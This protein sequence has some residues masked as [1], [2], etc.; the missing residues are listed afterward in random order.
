MRHI[1]RLLLISR[2]YWRWMVIAL[3]AM[4]GVAA[5]NLAGPW[6]IK[7]LVGTV[8]QSFAHGTAATG[9]VVSISAVLLLV[10]ALKHALRALQVSAAHV[11]GWGAVASARKRIYEH[12]LEL[13]PKYYS[14]TRTG[15][16][17][18]WTVNITSNFESL[19][20][21]VIPESIVS[22]LTVAGVVV[23]LFSTNP[24]LALYTL[25]PIPLIML[26]FIAY[27]RYVRP[28]FF[29]A[30]AR[31]GD[32]S[33]I[34]QD[35]LGGMREIQAFAQE[36]RSM[37]SVG[38]RIMAHSSSTAKALSTSAWFHGGLDF[39]ASLGRS[40]FCC[41]ARPDGATENRCPSLTS[42]VPSIC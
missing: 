7:S 19:I 8:E 15:S 33:A 27:N 30:Q 35:N 38:K 10:Y 40:R 25:A 13:S 41:S 42:L 11:A 17:L 29:Y 36:E 39:F 1:T 24:R 23:V 3:T 9:Q 4:L 2:E 32:L 18:S 34:L 28:L 37:E 22:L 5:A 31:L 14:H 16:I 21:H 12:V 26:G 6:L 20:A